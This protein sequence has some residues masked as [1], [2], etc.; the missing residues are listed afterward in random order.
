M[1]V[2]GYMAP[3]PPG[4]ELAT[5]CTEDSK[6]APWAGLDTLMVKRTNSSPTGNQTQYP[7]TLVPECPSQ[8]LFG[9]SLQPL[10][11]NVN[12][13]TSLKILNAGGKYIFTTAL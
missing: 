13:Q 12:I 5:H 6:G 9:L 8:V 1:A 4:E 7:I 2:S 11:I 10:Q 3:M